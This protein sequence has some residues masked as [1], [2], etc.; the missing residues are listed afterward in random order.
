[1]C[2][3]KGD[4]TASDHYWREQEAHVLSDIQQSLG[5]PVLIPNDTTITST[6]KGIL[7]LSKHLTKEGSTAKIL[8]GLASAS[9]LSLEKLCDDGCKVFLI[10]K[11]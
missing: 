11:S 5:P 7:L 9:L 8:S 3:A 6:K 10:R 1:M 4:S 2:V